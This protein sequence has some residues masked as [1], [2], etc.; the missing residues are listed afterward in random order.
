LEPLLS[1]VLSA[2]F[3]CVIGSPLITGKQVLAGDL[4]EYYFPYRHF[5]AQ[6]L[7]TGES[8]YWMHARS[9]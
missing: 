3:F 1:A 7:K 4:G 2:F 5:Y 6:C 8:P 9:F